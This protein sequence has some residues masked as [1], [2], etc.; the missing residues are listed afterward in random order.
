MR[1]ISD[2]SGAGRFRVRL[3]SATTRTVLRH[4]RRMM[5][6]RAEER[7]L[8]LELFIGMAVEYW[9]Q[10]LAFKT[11]SSGSRLEGYGVKHMP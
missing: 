5:C 10:T 9:A 2:I 11:K 7:R 6:V 1:M 3:G 8:W 4:R